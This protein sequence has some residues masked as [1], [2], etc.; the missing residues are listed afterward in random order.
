[1]AAVFPGQGNQRVGMAS[2]LLRDSDVAATA[3]GALS[4]LL[5]LDLAATMARGPEE[6][7]TPTRVAQAAVFTASVAAYDVLSREQAPLAVAGHSVGEIA[8]CWAAGAL[9]LD[10]AC[11]L[12]AARGTLMSEAPRG[13]MLAV[14]GLTR[15]EVAAVVA[16]R[17][18]VCIALHN[19]ERDVVLSGFPAAL[20]AVA[21]DLTAYP[22]RAS[23][24]RTSHAF[25]SPDFLPATARW[26]DVLRHAAI[27]VPSVPVAMNV[28]GSLTTDPEHIRTALADMLSSE[29]R[30]LDCVR[31]LR[32]AGA[33]VFV[34]CGDSQSLCRLGREHGGT[35][36]SFHVR[37]DWRRARH[38]QRGMAGAAR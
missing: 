19:G 26:R 15:D 20:D 24:L 17:A 16:G 38:A 22:C 1:M 36:H 30:W 18:G 21:E 5:G 13:A 8:A 35:W 29:V 37:N 34:E 31:S 33:E 32:S 2:H 10:E 4:D 28:D 23:V 12:I 11:R 9:D 3:C 7:L 6:V 14:T 27:S 25:H